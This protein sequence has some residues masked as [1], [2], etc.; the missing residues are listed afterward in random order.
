M[1]D[2]RAVISDK[3]RIEW[4]NKGGSCISPEQ[5]PEF[6]VGM[7]EEQIAKEIASSEAIPPTAG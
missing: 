3:S 4:L 5:T 6:F 7:S 1:T 2:L